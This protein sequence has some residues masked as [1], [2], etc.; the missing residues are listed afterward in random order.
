M[1]VIVEKS[2]P[3]KGSIDR[4]MMHTWYGSAPPPES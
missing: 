1:G 3:E 4:G 2:V